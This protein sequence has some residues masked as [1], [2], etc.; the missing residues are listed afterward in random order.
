[1]DWIERVKY[2]GCYF[3]GDVDTANAVGKFYSSFNNILHVLCKQRNEM[4][5]VH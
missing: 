3:N 1:M 2:P 4:L 5:A